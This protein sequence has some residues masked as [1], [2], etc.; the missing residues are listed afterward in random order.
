MS[1]SI[2]QKQWQLFFLGYYGDTTDD[3]DGIWGSMSEAAT[4][5]AQED[6]G[7]K[8][9]G[10]FGENTAD[11]SREVIDAIQD[12]VTVYAKK[13]LVNDGLAG[14]ATMAAT[15]WYQKA[16]GLTPNGIADA[17]TRAYISDKVIAG[18]TT[19]P[20]E[21]A[22][23]DFLIGKIGNPFGVAGLMGNLY[24][25]S[26]LIPNN[27]Q[28]SYNTSLGYTD[29][30]YTNAVDKGSYANFVKD[31]AGYGL[32]QWTYHT[33]KKALLEYAREHNASIG[34]LSVQLDFLYEELSGSF[35]S[36]LTALEEATTVL[37][38]SNIVLTRYECPAD[39]GASV[40]TKRASFGQ[41]YYDSYADPVSSTEPEESS[42]ELWWDEIE[43]FTRE[44]LRCKCGKYCDGFPAEP[45]E[46][47]VRL[48]DRARKHFG[49]P[50]HN[51]SFLRCKK[52]NAL[53][54]GVAN[55]QHM[56][57]EAMD[58][59]IEGVSAEELVAFFREQPEVRYTYEINETNV[60]FDIPKGAR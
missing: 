11:K 40:Q 54:G 53:S 42:E 7:I 31:C 14:P 28:N 21:K 25:E 24:A 55:S 46:M 47:T 49:R 8:V 4:R 30:A 1:M 17:T 18:Q 26:C 39:Q 41:K 10:I 12:V 5:A 37:E 22:V 32:A 3:I 9:D 27:L 50:G 51:V 58:I 13:P 59:R 34:N 60:H 33:R 16:V 35:K 52:W 48:A 38:A 56:Y 36:V 44:E 29:E 45:K 2:K 23:W 6:F 43:Y 19:S 57:G 15:V 20:N